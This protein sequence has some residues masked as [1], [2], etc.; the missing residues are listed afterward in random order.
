[1][2]ETTKPNN[3]TTLM[4]EKPMDITD[5]IKTFEDACIELGVTSN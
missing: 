4:G 2:K 5:H 3:R 1:M